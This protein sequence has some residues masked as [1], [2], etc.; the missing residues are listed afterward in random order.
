LA[1]FD[2]S[3]K[4]ARKQAKEAGLTEAEFADIIDT[5]R[6]KKCDLTASPVCQSGFSV[7]PCG[8]VS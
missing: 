5:A 4:K 8:F 7:L 6:R 3:V 1:E 2:A